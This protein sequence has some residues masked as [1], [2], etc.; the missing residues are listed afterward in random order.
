MDVRRKYLLGLNEVARGLIA[1]GIAVPG[2]VTCTCEG[3]GSR[4]LLARAFLSEV[5]ISLGPECEASSHH[6]DR[7]FI[8]PAHIPST[9]GELDKLIAGMFDELPS[10]DVNT[11]KPYVKEI[12]EKSEDGIPLAK[13][14]ERKT[15]VLTPTEQA[16]LDRI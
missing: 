16:I 6:G 15:K 3:R 8:G 4:E 9:R 7:D 2:H 5:T 10:I 12:A 14:R 11:A 13:E 1:L